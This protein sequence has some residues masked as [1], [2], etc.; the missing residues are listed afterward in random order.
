[1]LV[2]NENVTPASMIESLLPNLS[3]KIPAGIRTKPDPMFEMKNSA[4]VSVS[5]RFNDR[6]NRGRS[7]QPLEN[8]KDI[9]KEDKARKPKP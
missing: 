1:M 7:I 6:V 9:R 2:D 4:P 8:P 3:E 5:V